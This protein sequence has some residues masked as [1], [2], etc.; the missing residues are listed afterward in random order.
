MHEAIVGELEE[1]LAGAASVQVQRRVRAHLDACEECRTEVAE[2]EEIGQLIRSLK[3]VEEMAPVPGFYARVSSR[4]ESQRPVGIWNALIDPAFFR[5]TAFACLMILALLGSYLVSRESDYGYTSPSPEVVIAIEQSQP[6]SPENPVQ[7][8]DMM[9]A[10][11]A[12]Y[13]QP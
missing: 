1:F 5:R 9:L 6:L 11:L 10:T 8:R 3:P 13:Q 4:I 12:S 7:D 2:M